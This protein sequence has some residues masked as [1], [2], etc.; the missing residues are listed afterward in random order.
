MRLR[1][2]ETPWGLARFTYAYLAALLAGVVAGVVALIA[3]PVMDATP[4]CEADPT[5][6]CLPGLTVSTGVAGLIGALFWMGFAFRLGWQWAAWTS[7]LVLILIE[8]IIQTSW[9]SAAGLFLVLPALA[10]AVTFERPDADSP[11]WLNL[12]RVIL[13]AVLA[14]QFV[15]WLVILLATPY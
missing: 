7:V 2:A 8:V 3:Y 15:V 13:L 9:V 10:A 5:G 11:G 1:L 6:L 14:I 4:L 12:V